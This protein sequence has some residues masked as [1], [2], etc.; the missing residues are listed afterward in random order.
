[1][2][3]RRSNRATP[4]ATTASTFAVAAAAALLLPLLAGCGPPEKAAREPAEPVGAERSSRTPRDGYRR[5]SSNLEHFYDAPWRPI[6]VREL[7]ES[8]E[9][10]HGRLDPHVGLF[11]NRGEG[12]IVLDTGRTRIAFGLAEPQQLG[13]NTYSFAQGQLE[14]ELVDRDT[15]E[16][17]YIH[18]GSR[19]RERYIRLNID[20]RE[21]VEGVQEERNER[22]EQLRSIA[23]RL[24]SDRYGTIVL[25]GNRTVRWT[26]REELEPHIIPPDAPRV[27]TLRFDLVLARRVSPDYTGAFSLFFDLGLRSARRAIAYRIEEEGLGLVY[28]PAEFIELDIVQ[29]IPDSSPQ[30]FFRAS[31]GGG[32]GGDNK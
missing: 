13:P 8:H 11:P 25:N 28:V 16:A 14:I 23:Q 19:V 21:V 6:Y 9:D 27:A 7:L 30:M 26:D 31:A 1:M 22:Y 24:V 15:L 2:S 10:R 4:G 18:R 32:G 20:L 12:R 3:V 5:S 29:A 17:H